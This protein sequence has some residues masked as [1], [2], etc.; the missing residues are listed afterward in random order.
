MAL[1]LAN[2]K[3]C[4]GA[5]MQATQ[6]KQ[7][8]KR[9]VLSLPHGDGHRAHARPRNPRNPPF[10]KT[11]LQKGVQKP[12][13]LSSPFLPERYPERH[14]ERGGF[15]R[16]VSQKGGVSGVSG[17]L[18]CKAE[19]TNRGTVQFPDRGNRAVDG[20]GGCGETRHRKCPPAES[21]LREWKGMGGNQTATRGVW[22][23]IKVATSPLTTTEGK[24]MHFGRP[25]FVAGHQSGHSTRGSPGDGNGRDKNG[26]PGCV[27]GHQSGHVTPN[28]NG[29]ERHALWPPRV[30]G[31]P[32]KWPQHPRVPRGREWKGQKRPPGVCGRPSK[33]PRHP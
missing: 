7:W 5:T 15:C 29:R 20:P 10:W 32:S 1:Q 6:L 4:E 33:W 24:G 28:H 23:A 27:A 3:T 14:P 30:C 12:P 9:M 31:W 25:G 18:V 21:M 17:G 16:K 2:S 13:P 19:T 22:P 26:H 8:A 11:F